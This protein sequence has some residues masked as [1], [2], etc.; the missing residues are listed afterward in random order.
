MLDRVTTALAL[1]NTAIFLVSAD[2]E[3]FVVYLARGPAERVAGQVRIPLGQG[4]AGR[5]ATSRQPLI[6][7]DLSA[8]AA[9]NPFLR[10]TM[11][12]LMGVP[13]LVG[14]RVI[15]VLG[16]HEIPR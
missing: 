3:A 12:A 14:D 1:D 16:Q 8:V 11:H 13:L 4:I 9:V 6:V 15:G 2:E 10:E 7:D 5:I